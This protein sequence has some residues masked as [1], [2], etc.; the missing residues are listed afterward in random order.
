MMRRAVHSVDAF[1]ADELT[2]E[3]DHVVRAV[4]EQASGGVLFKQNLFVV[5]ENFNGIVGIQV[6]ALAYFDRKHDPSDFVKL[7]YDTG[8]F[9][10]PFP[11]FCKYG[12]IEYYRLE[13]ELY[14]SC[15]FIIK[16]IFQKS[17]III[18]FLLK[19]RKK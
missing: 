14:Q 1:F 16:I 8:R 7:S 12:S 5:Y 13:N 18:H 10:N 6:K 17:I 9:H 3:E 4:A 15:I 19:N 11:P 2:V